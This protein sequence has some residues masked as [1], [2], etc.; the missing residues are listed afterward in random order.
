MS[1]Y[2]QFLRLIRDLNIEAQ[3]D[4]DTLWRSVGGDPVALGEVLAELVQSY[5]DAAA[6]AAAT[7]YDEVRTDAGVTPGFQAVLPEPREPGT[8]ALVGWAADQ[9]NSA[10][11]F[12]SL[13]GGGVQR[14]ITNYSREVLTTSSVRDPRARGWM[15]VGAG[16]CD[17][18]AMLISRG[19]VYTK[20]SVRFASHDS[21][22][23]GVA[24]AWSSGQVA[25]VRSEFVPS[26][27]RR[28]EA[29]SEADRARVRA[30]IS[31]NL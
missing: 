12:R 28:S 21:C 15:R 24:P 9:A 31:A 18:C 7:W 19:A 14:R 20:E 5:G 16:A 13:I 4:L 25:S 26:S 27:R 2:Q 1:P 11:S 29:A 6:A 30:W 22:H 23:C 8:Y 3:R 17:F 10:D